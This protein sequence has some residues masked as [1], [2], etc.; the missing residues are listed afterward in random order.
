M[1][2]DLLQLVVR[3]RC[4]NSNFAIIRD[5]PGAI[6]LMLDVKYQ[7]TTLPRAQH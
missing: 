1:S 2:C 7:R 4:D 5:N 3:S 6:F